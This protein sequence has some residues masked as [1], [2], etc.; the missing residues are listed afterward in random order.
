MTYIHK[1]NNNHKVIISNL[2]DER[3]STQQRLKP[4]VILIKIK[5]PRNHRS[6]NVL[7]CLRPA[8]YVSTL[9]NK[10]IYTCISSNINLHSQTEQKK[11]RTLSS[12]LY[13]QQHDLEYFSEII[14]NVKSFK[15]TL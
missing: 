12:S 15:V 4:S 10:I 3:S 9:Q 13:D 7:Y 14:S 8:S 6:H 2:Y 11:T 1:S 5:F